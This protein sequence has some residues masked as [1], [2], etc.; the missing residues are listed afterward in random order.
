MIWLGD[1]IFD[2][3]VKRWTREDGFAFAGPCAHKGVILDLGITKGDKAGVKK[4]ETKKEL[5]NGYWGEKRKTYTLVDRV[6]K[7]MLLRDMF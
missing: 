7:H 4:G 1:L 3:V 2:R 6:T 5:H